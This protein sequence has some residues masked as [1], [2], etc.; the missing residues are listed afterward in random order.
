MRS[1][2]FPGPRVT[3]SQKVGWL[4]SGFGQNHGRKHERKKGRG[5]SHALALKLFWFEWKLK[6]HSIEL[7]I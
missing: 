4:G 1:I 5:S 2:D 7:G 6:P 3:I